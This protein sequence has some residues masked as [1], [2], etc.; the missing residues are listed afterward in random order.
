MEAR[1]LDIFSDNGIEQG[2]PRQ[3]ELPL[4]VSAPPLPPGAQ[5]SLFPQ[6]KFKAPNN[7]KVIIDIDTLQSWKNQIVE[8][9]QQARNTK[10]GEQKALFELPEIRSEDYTQIDPLKLNNQVLSKYK[11]TDYLYFVLDKT[12]GLILYIGQQRVNKKL[13]KVHEF[14]EHIT[15]YQ[16]L[17]NYYKLK[18]SI[19]I[20]FWQSV[21]QD[22]YRRQELE[23]Y[24]ILKWRAPFNK[25]SF[26][27]W[28]L[29]F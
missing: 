22:S 25:Q 19:S 9:Q 1:Q 27:W 16:E 12:P 5:L 4:D 10:P 11:G 21:P 26:Q 7:E 23:E 17:H 13:K 14:N 24:F 29:P 3:L 28:G 18:T 8:Y 2:Q 20:V 15:T 6:A